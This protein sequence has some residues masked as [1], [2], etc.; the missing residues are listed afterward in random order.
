MM[1][2]RAGKGDNL[3][4]PRLPLDEEYPLLAVLLALL[5]SP[6]PA[7][8]VA[9]FITVLT[10]MVAPIIATHNIIGPIPPLA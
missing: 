2:L 3:R 1:A 8:V 7:M 5:L 6:L 9:T 4:Y 10:A